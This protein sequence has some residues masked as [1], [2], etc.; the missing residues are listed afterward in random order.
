MANQIKY[1]VGFDVHKEGLNQ[2]K[3]SLQQLQKMKISDLMK[4]NKTDYDSASTL[5]GDIK[6]EAVKVEDALKKAFNVKLNTVN[7][8]SFNKQL[9]ST[10]SSIEKVYSTFSKA[11]A[12]GQ[13][14]F[15]NLT[16]QVLKTNIQLKESHTLLDNMATTL[17]NTVK[18]NIASGAV[19]QLSQSIQ[20][21]F[22][23]VK[24]LDTSLNNIRIVTNKTAD[25]MGAFAERANEA[26]QSLGKST[27]DYTDAAL[28]FYQQG[29]DDKQAQKRAEIT[30]KAANVTG[31]STDQA[32]EQL[33]AVWNGYKVSA[34]E[35]ELYVDRL[36]AVAATTASDLEELSTGMSKVASAANIMGVGQDQLAAQISTIISATREAPETVGMAL[37][38]IYARINDIKS[39]MADDGATLGRF[40]SQMAE[41]GFNILDAQGHL[42]DMGDVIEEIG[43]KWNDLTREQQVSLAQIAGGKYQY[44]RFLSL[45]DNWDQY[46]KALET[47]RNAE[48]ALQEQ[49]DI[50]MDSTI[51]HLNTLKAAKENIFQ[52]LADTDS[53][54]DLID[55]LTS[56]ANIVAS[57]VDSIGGGGQILKDLGAIGIS[58]FSNQIAKSINTTITNFETARN[59][60]N[61]FK[62]SLLEIQKWQGIPGLNETTK[63]ILNNKQQ[64]V[65]LA[66]VMSPEQFSGA[67]NTL[68]KITQNLSQVG[69]LSQQYIILKKAT[70]EIV[71]SQNSFNKAME[72]NQV[73]Q[74][75]IIDMLKKQ[76]DEYTKLSGKIA[77]HIKTIE[78][79]GTKD[80]FTSATEGLQTYLHQLENLNGK[81]WT[82]QHREQIKILKE[83]LKNLSSGG[84]DDSLIAV[85]LKGV[86]TQINA[87]VNVSQKS[88]KNLRQ[89][90]TEEFEGGI[91]SLTEQIEILK[92][93]I[94][95]LEG[96]FSKTVDEG[97][98]T[99]TI[100]SYAKLAGG[101]T[102]VG[103]SIQ[104]VQHLGSIWKNNDLSQGEKLLQTVTNLGMTL[105]MLGTGIKSVIDSLKVLTAGST[106]AMGA[107]GGLLAVIAVATT[108]F[109]VYENHQ[110]QL[111]ENEKA[112]NDQSIQ[113]EKKNQAEIENNKE[114]LKS[115]EQ[116]D[117]QYKNGQITRDELKTNVQ[118]LIQQYHL[119]G[120]A[121][122]KLAD[123]YLNLSNYIQQFSLKQATAYK[124]SLE[125]QKDSAE[126]N[127][128]L[129]AQ[130]D[131]SQTKN[132]EV[133]ISSSLQGINE[134]A[135][136]ISEL[137]K[138][139]FKLQETYG[140][141]A[142][143]FER[144]SATIKANLSDGASIVEFYEKIQD[145]VQNINALDLDGKILAR[146]EY[147][148]S[149][150][151]I[152]KDLSD[153]YKE[154][155][156]VVEAAE[157][158]GAQQGALKAIED[159]EVDFTS[160]KTANEYLDQ[161]TKLID[162]LKQKYDL[163]AEAAQTFVSK[164]LKQNYS[165]VYTQFEQIS[166]SLDKF[167]DKIGEEIPQDI[168]N[169]VRSFNDQQFA[170]FL[171][172]D[173]ETFQSWNTLRDTL[174]EISQKDFSNVKDIASMR[175]SAEQDYT[176]FSSLQDQVS[177]GKN[178]SN[179]EF[180]SLAERGAENLQE[181]FDKAANGT[182]KMVGD[183]QQFQAAVDDLKFEGFYEVL[184]EI[185]QKID[186][187]NNANAQYNLESLNSSALT[188]GFG[189][190]KD[191][192]GPIWGAV[193]FDS[194]KLLQ[195][196]NYLEEAK[197]ISEEQAEISED[198][199]EVHKDDVGVSQQ[200]V[201][202]C[203]QMTDKISETAVSSEDLKQEWNQVAMQIHDAM[204]PLDEDVDTSQ[205]ERLTEL[206][207][208]S[209]DSIEGLNDAIKGNRDWAEDAATAV[210]RYDDAIQDLIDNYEEWAD[211]LR[212][213]SNV[214]YV[215][216]ADDL[217]DAYED[218]LDFVGDGALS[219][220]FLRNAENLEL[221]RIA[222]GD[223]AEG[224]QYSVDQIEAAYDRLKE[225]ALQ[226]IITHLVL[227][228]EQ[229]FWSK[230]NSI[231]DSIA[232][233][234]N[235]GLNQMVLTADMDPTGFINSFNEM[236]AMTDAG[237]A[238]AENLLAAM[239]F[240]A[241]VIESSPE[242]KTETT[243]TEFVRPPK[244]QARKD[245]AGNMITEMTEQP[246]VIPVDISTSTIIPGTG[247]V[248]IETMHKTTGG[249]IKYLQSSNGGGSTGTTSR[250]TKRQ[251]IEDEN[252]KAAE[253]EQKRIEAEQ[254]KAQQEADRLAREQKR[255]EQKAA[256]EAE[257]QRKQQERDAEKARKQSEA[258]AKKAQQQTEKAQK[259]WEK[260]NSDYRTKDQ[261]KTIEDERDLYHDINIEIS[262]V[263]R[264][265]ARIQKRQERMYG[266][267]LI[268]NLNKQSQILENHK[269]LLKEKM[270]IQEYDLKLQKAT[271]E[272]LGVTFD[273]YGNI[274]NYMTVMAQKQDYINK[275]TEE[276]NLLV[277]QYNA[278]SNKT[279][280]DNLEEQMKL[281]EKQTKAAEEEWKN[282][283]SKIKNYDKLREQIQD[284]IDD[285]D[286][287][288]QKQ[289][290]INIKKF[291]MQLEIRL[292]LGQAERDW[293]QFTRK[294][295]NHTDIIRD[296]DFSKIYKDAD[297]NYADMLSYYGVRGGKGE[298]QKYTEQLY[299]TMEEI[300][301]INTLGWSE[302]YGDNKQQA[303]EDLTSDL[304][305]LQGI[306]IDINDYVDQIDQAYLDTIDNAQKH[307]D[308]QIKDYKFVQ[309]LLNKDMD[310]LQLLYGD[311]NYA[312]MDK[313][314][315]QLNENHKN[316]LDFLKQEAAYWKT[317]WDNAENKEDKDAKQFKQNYMNA[318]NSIRD[319]I[320]KA[321]KDLQSQFTNSINTIFD[322]LDKKLT[323][324]KGLDYVE[325]E[326]Q[327][328]NKNADEYL[329]TI[330]SAFAIQELE[331]KFR[332]A[333]NDTSTKN[334]KAQRAIK[335][336]MDEQLGALKT[337]EKITQYDVDR[338]QKLLEIEQARAA[339]E[340]AR[341]SKTSMRLK[342][343]SQG[344]YSYEYVADQDGII[345]AQ[346]RL[347]T[348]QNELYNFDKDRYKSNL[349]DMLST[350]KEFKQKQMQLVELAKE[351]NEQAQ[352]ELLLLQQAYGEYMNDKTEQNLDIRTN[353][354]ES[355]FQEIANIYGT[356]I[357]S[358][359]NMADTER[360][361]LLND[362][363]PYWNSGI[364]QMSDK[365][366]GDGGF[367]PTCENAFEKITET[368]KN[369]EAQLGELA[370]QAGVDLEEV[371]SGVDNVSDS[372]KE[373]IS[374]NQQLIEVTDAEIEVVRD[375]RD[376]AHALVD[377]YNAVYQ[378]ALKACSAVQDFTQA[379]RQQA[380]AEAEQYSTGGDYSEDSSPMPTPVPGDQQVNAYTDY[381]AWEDP[382]WVPDFN[383]QVGDV[384]T[385]D[386]SYYHDS[387]GKNPA[388]NKYSG[389]E[390]GVIIDSYSS[391]EYGGKANK[392]GDYD[393]HIMSAD[394]VY[395]DLGWIKRS[396]LRGFA[397]G[398]YTGNWAGEEGRIGILHQKEM[399]LNQ[400]D[401]KNLLNT[402]NIL[403]SMMGNLNGNIYSKLGGL[404]SD[405]Y[406][407][408]GNSDSLEQNVHID[409]TFPNVNSKREI[410]QAFND[411]V[412]LAAQRALRQ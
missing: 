196:I 193:G 160:I 329:D 240:D 343:D 369:Y 189:Q 96:D 78:S 109:S 245:E 47:A 212:Q 177:S 270:Q 133:S 36:A 75:K 141:Y 94:K 233:W 241:T 40:S 275:L 225:A 231:Q 199:V 155:K 65:Q 228:D 229:G 401:T 98:R 377:E 368:T 144:Q 202:L 274:S 291:R 28:I 360:N 207:A 331:G 129:A 8:E 316:E 108:A 107:I 239:G 238:E 280:K 46:V 171:K 205:L 339:L 407:P 77:Q 251:K 128:K 266:K 406:K 208:E 81:D 265:L 298:I 126:S 358:Y 395:T 219:D 336:L 67:Q 334:L 226:D 29:L 412:N 63:Q 127:L 384:V 192:Q 57:F 340:D 330:N 117:E 5:L 235:Q 60:A 393:V 247:A 44:A 404:K 305:N 349:E 246:G 116:L 206:Y 385:F 296:S 161:R 325:L 146:S 379:E 249:G 263:D 375:L 181:F 138:A 204:L 328:I 187:I 394:G 175:A 215:Q 376:A 403:R 90:L 123:S 277:A 64:I 183:I 33:T 322:Q 51:A 194:D 147:Y 172:L 333:L 61:Q 185:Q 301:A 84:V 7:I 271:L 398:G 150:K 142:T 242:V 111:I 156:D 282:T 112:L 148:K 178:I 278:S 308:D 370:R 180:E 119:E 348:A 48:G 12:V 292:E 35:A 4:I 139:G 137:E 335:N 381:W 378:S 1:Q 17:A 164:F 34:D 132:G 188:Y 173:P 302:V 103:M 290:E 254:K 100:Q 227:E 163:S 387:W 261:K 307:F 86:A 92:Q 2:L 143:G 58:V 287:Q 31:Q 396:Q 283:Q 253:A 71:E 338:V 27:T 304:S 232:E 268:A 354:T 55:G 149:L 314:Y 83:Q 6:N 352:R 252:A 317:Q 342:R 293:N 297:L 323:N 389:V 410:E 30:L 374:D 41:Y 62:Q 135:K 73:Q 10:G 362:L 284:I 279:Y 372:F 273:A 267:D 131:I 166:G 341:A 16:S 200:I 295:I 234:Q 19:N 262:H 359:Q 186:D 223:Q 286:D 151:T 122:D 79:A 121:A 152:L 42:R 214:E 66:K 45:F 386:G 363:I 23:Y 24:A 248:Q 167:K 256:R 18:W 80:E 82:K 136:I 365:I 37:K 114:L 217:A 20:Q 347:A 230:F 89:Q 337:K 216:I 318:V 174:T 382:N 319:E 260:E 312:A 95:E 259:E 272:S 102:S 50:Y 198:L 93:R 258:A 74:Q 383:P 13:G 11:G 255:A 38:T 221:F 392:T 288:T 91:N 311:K 313:Y 222:A 176:Y 113:E 405:I 118:K 22:G 294:V 357:Q 157:K 213:G 371:K 281:K 285:I 54:N 327:L 344:N 14:A 203:Q 399:V 56:A 49:Q 165:Q 380:A 356:D 134:D 159:K 154:Y 353:L 244:Y 257:Q 32:S 21:A 162:I 168:E 210:L 346:Q 115:L 120:E 184:N 224:V 209:A 69:K 408:N 391:S 350:Y 306:L 310:L 179:K 15:R 397:S 130:S 169:L 320:A 326:W 321:A 145:T 303:M 269:D 364:Q 264:Q 299:E 170:E 72:G 355:A 289:I 70:L 101:I 402:V 53:I 87:L 158:A 195:Q 197:T 190:S 43:G 309:G 400:Q 105:P 182:Y 236:L 411:L 3:S 388:G 220:E 76:Q 68:D 243:T 324:G 332:K 26:A 106:A 211:V 110:K 367:I 39:G 99:S 351:G 88:A 361:I 104:Q 300:N 124:E 125:R 153:E 218:L 315:N 140:D 373:L 409:A 191:I 276:Y 237:V 25:D 59:N 390:G 250:A 366:A 85:K 201:D 97:L 345:E 52:S 9:T